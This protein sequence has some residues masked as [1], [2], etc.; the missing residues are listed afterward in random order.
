MKRALRIIVPLV[1]AVAVVGCMVWYLLVYDRDF[2]KDLLLSQARNF[3]SAGNHKASAWLYDIAYYHSSQEPEVAIE[4]ARQHKAAGN[5]TKAEYTL[6]KAISLSSDPALYAEL[7]AT[8]V[9]QDKLLDAVTMLDSITDPAIKVELDARRPQAPIL[10][11]EPGFYSQ[12]I[13]VT[14][15]SAA[16]ALYISTNREYPSTSFPYSEPVVLAGG[17]TTIYSL[18]VSDEGLVSP[19][20]VG[21]YTVG[22]VIEQVSFADAAME[23][24]IRVALGVG[25][26]AILYTDDLWTITQFSVPAEV[27]SYE[28]LSLLTYLRS[29]TIDNGTDSDLSGLSKLTGLE[30]L[31]VSG[32]RLDETELTAIGTLAS[33]QRLTLNDCS[34]TSIA[35]LEKLSKLVY[36]DLGSNA[37]RNISVLAGMSG[38]QELSLHSNALT[39]LSSLSGLTGLTKLDV[40]YNSLTSLSPI[41][42]LSGLKTLDVSHNQLASADSISN[43]TGLTSLNLSNNALIDCAALADCVGLTEL[44]VS[45]NTL[46]DI[47]KLSALTGLITLNFSYNQVA[48]LPAFD[49]ECALV[50]VDGSHNQ[51]TSLDP[52]SGLQELNNV[53]MDYNEKLSSLK[54]LD[55][56]PLLVLVNAYGT[57]ITEVSFLTQKSVIVNFDPT[58]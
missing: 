22:G 39:D 15:E 52:L 26:D 47:S 40:S 8:Y 37:I 31:T 30:E 9:E 54:P 7:C 28:D 50:T 32:C 3:E 41:S 49:K 56:C 24:A 21:G 53:L 6:S 13:S 10:K 33:L 2:T 11:P 1:L 23:S 4:L 19:M 38:L 45:N 55:N 58:V 20:T 36:L 35:P 18:A 34:L 51:I 43:L 27:A 44:N 16:P 17:E 57:K 25:A 29:L 12:Y 5:Y 48:T 46:T 14:A 42:G